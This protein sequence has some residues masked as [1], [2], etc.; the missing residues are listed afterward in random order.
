MVWCKFA[1]GLNRGID[2][3][4]FSH[5]LV[6]KQRSR[7]KPLQLDGYQLDWSMELSPLI[8]LKVE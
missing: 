7:S 4:V 8:D 1:R 6:K 5:S 2:E 3:L